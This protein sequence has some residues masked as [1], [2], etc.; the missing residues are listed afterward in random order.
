MM[1]LT[2]TQ[3]RKRLFNLLD[4]ANSSHSP[5]LIE[6]KRGGAVLIGMEDWSAIEET[7]FLTSIPDMRESIKAG[8][9]MPLRKTSKVVKW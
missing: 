8:M 2:V 7:L 5:I 4:E 9:K 3:A 6:G 1:A